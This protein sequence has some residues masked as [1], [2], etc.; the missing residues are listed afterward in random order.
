MKPVILYAQFGPLGGA[1]SET[2]HALKLWRRFGVDLTLVP[3]GGPLNAH[4]HERIADTGCKI[5]WPVPKDCTELPGIENSIA[6][7]FCHHFFWL[8]ISHLKDRGAKIVWVPCMSYAFPESGD[9]VDSI[10]AWVCQSRYQRGVFLKHFAEQGIPMERFHLVRGAFDLADFP[11]QPKARTPGDPFV[12]GR[13][14]RPNPNK[15]HKRTWEIL[16]RIPDVRARVLGWCGAVRSRIGQAPPWAETLLPGAETPQNFLSTL[17]CLIQLGEVAENWPQVG[18]EAMAAGVPIIADNRGGWPEMIRHGETGFLCDSPED[19]AR[20]AT[21]LAQ[22]AAERVR[23]IQAAR[24]AVEQ[25][26][27]PERLWR[28]WSRLFNSLSSDH[29]EMVDI[30]ESTRYSAWATTGPTGGPGK[31]VSPV[32]EEDSSGGGLPRLGFSPHRPSDREA[33]RPPS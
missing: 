32:D 27:Q 20:W 1:V 17:D 29:P 16:A 8:L 14:S 22:D 28:P 13:I 10:D 3:L 26:A 4:W 11:F 7:S 19:A 24:E 30:V 9:F 18:M 5:V 25:M 33:S 21:L 12:V 6:L 31:E 15:F 2:W 23:I